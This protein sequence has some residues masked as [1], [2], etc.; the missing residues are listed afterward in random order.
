MK[1]NAIGTDLCLGKPGKMN[2]SFGADRKRRTLYFHDKD[3]RL[4]SAT[5]LEKLLLNNFK[6]QVA[7]LVKNPELAWCSSHRYR[8]SLKEKHI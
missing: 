6:I 4:F 8:V 5:L 7:K 2:D 1:T 3:S